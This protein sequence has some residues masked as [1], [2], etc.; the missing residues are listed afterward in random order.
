MTLHKIVVIGLGKLGA[1]LAAVLAD[2][3][4]TVC[5]VDIDEG[6]VDK[7]NRGEAPVFEPGLRDLVKRGRE[8]G[9]LSATISYEIA[10]RNGADATFIVVPTPSNPDGS[11]SLKH[12]EEA[13]QKVG[14]VMSR[15]NAYHLIVVVSTVSPGSMVKV[16]RVIKEA[17]A[18]MYKRDW[19]LAYN[20]EFIALGNV[21]E[22]LRNPD[23][24]LIGESDKRAG[25][26]LE[27]IYTYVR[28]T[29]TTPKS[30]CLLRDPYDTP[31]KR[32][33]FINAEIAKIAL[34]SYVTMKI[35]FA[36]TL[37]EICEKTEG[38]D[39]DV[40]TDVLGED[41]RIGAKYLKGGLG[42]GGTCFPRDNKAFIRFAV[43]DGFPP[44][45]T[46]CKLAKASDAVNCMIPSRIVHIIRDLGLPVGSR[47]GVLGLTYKPGTNIVEESQAL[48]VAHYT[49]LW[50]YDVLAFD[51]TQRVI[52]EA[53]IPGCGF[54]RDRMSLA[55][56]A[57]ECVRGSDVVVLATPWPEFRNLDPALFKGKTVVDCWR[58]FKDDVRREC[59]KYVAVGV[60]G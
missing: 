24:V 18:S 57:E 2:A 50:G 33:S 29:H 43:L 51:P 44:N 16:K 19:G 45:H 39:V 40:V 23:F 46:R 4:F 56:S 47:V 34:N 1:C 27:E 37:A 41:G 36:N 35:S 10:Y 3:G 11:F 22:G 5:G 12:V 13:A 7:V 48:T 28:F 8:N 53:L 32:T 14:E 31:I 26:T 6:K 15:R 30:P 60:N 55:P 9:R 54:L 58:F 25:D 38:G 21:I 49:S 59:K 52:M 42:Y 20:P 17:S